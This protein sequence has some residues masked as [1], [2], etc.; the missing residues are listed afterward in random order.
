[1]FW[2]QCL[3]RCT[4]I[5]RALVND[6]MILCTNS[7]IWVVFSISHYRNSFVVNKFMQW[8]F[9]HVICSWTWLSIYIQLS[10]TVWIKKYYNGCCCLLYVY[11]NL[12]PQIIS[13]CFLGTFLKKFLRMLFQFWNGIIYSFYVPLKTHFGPSQFSRGPI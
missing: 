3:V 11:A 6:I 8:L 10:F 13:C 4:L 5:G 7:S 12:K 9:C 1:M 2:I